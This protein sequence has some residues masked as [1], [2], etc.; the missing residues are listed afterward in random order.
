MKYI[1]ICCLV[2]LTTGSIVTVM[3]RPSVQSHKPILYWVTDP[4]PTRTKQ[5]EVFEKWLDENYGDELQHKYGF[6]TFELKID[7]ANSDL[8]KKVIQGVS[9][10]G[11]DIMDITSSR[12]MTYFV[13]MGLL[14]DISSGAQHFGFIQENTYPNLK[15]EISIDT[16]QYLYPANVW[17]NLLWINKDTFNKYGLPIPPQ[18]WDFDT[19]EKL[20]IEFV[21][22]A[23][24]PGE[25]QKVFFCSAIQLKNLYRS[26]GISTFNETLT[27][28]NLNDPKYINLLKRI[29]KWIYEYHIIPSVTDIASFSTDSGYKGSSRQLFNSGNYGMFFGD[30]ADLIQLRQF[31]KL[32]LAIAGTPHGGFPN[33]YIGVRGVSIYSGSKHP[34]LA[35]YFLAYLTSREYNMLVIEHADALPPN[36]KFTETEEFK[37]PKDYPNECGIHEFFA[38]SLK[39]IGLPVVY[40]PFILPQVVERIENE[41]HDGFMSHVYTAEQTAKILEQRINEE[42]QITLK[43]NH[44]LMEKYNRL[45]EKQ[46][47]IDEMLS[48]GQIVPIEMIDNI[49]YRHYY[50]FIGVAK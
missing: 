27:K 49:F 18:S 10:V 32:N 1:F 16:K 11:G 29:Y 13:S 30:R 17:C 4:N 48:T 41:V 46:K 45:L 14:K 44:Y 38:N 5:V 21:K 43:E 22:A 25:R 23:N 33:S 26:V 15:T 20:G 37:C 34:E 42:I 8:A 28:C 40:S 7:S 35:Q 36:P 3:M 24:L 12:E 19:F 39:T 2:I 6:R 50:K 47:T 31:G 9:G